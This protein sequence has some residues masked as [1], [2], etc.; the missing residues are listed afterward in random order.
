MG[1]RQV[2]EGC[3]NT[4]R[5]EIPTSLLAHL[6]SSGALTGNDCRCLDN[7]ARKTLWQSLLNLSVEA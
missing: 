3:K 7:N 2:S 5:V 1:I 4:A 6:I